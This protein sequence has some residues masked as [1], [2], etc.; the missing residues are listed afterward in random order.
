MVNPSKLKSL[1]DSHSTNPGMAALTNPS[2][3][4][5]GDDDDDLDEEDDEGDGAPSGDPK[6]HGNELISSW[7]VL[8][9]HLKEDA[10]E[11]VDAA[12]EIGG[13][14]LLAKVPDE[15]MKEIE[16]SFD[17]MPEEIQHA[18]AKYV[19]K[20]SDEDCHDVTVALLDGHDGDTEDADTNLVCT[21]LKLLAAHAAEEVDPADL[22]DDEDEEDD[23]DDDEENPGDDGDGASMNPDDGT[24]PAVHDGK[25][26]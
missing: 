13:D 2:M 9:A 11:I 16:D 14:L 21:Y 5:G 22:E 8:G 15:A 17:R 1:V 20:L 7:G 3:Q 6:E 24:P 19:S 12:H 4:V 25:T 23:E 10:G 18:L 26:V